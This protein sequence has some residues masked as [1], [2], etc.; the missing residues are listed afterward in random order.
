MSKEKEY[1]IPASVVKKMA[2]I[3]ELA[4]NVELF[5][6]AADYASAEIER[7]TPEVLEYL[8]ENAGAYNVGVRKNLAVGITGNIMFKVSTRSSIT[9]VDGKREDDQKWLEKLPADFVRDRLSLNKQVVERVFANDVSGALQFTPQELKKK[10]GIVREAAQTLKV[11][12][13][14]SDAEMEQLK[15]EATELMEE[16]TESK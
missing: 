1:K 3:A 12:A 16:G 13:A 2:R 7:L 5:K 10:Y 14:Y 9:R 11:S 15:L 6:G 8:G 4:K